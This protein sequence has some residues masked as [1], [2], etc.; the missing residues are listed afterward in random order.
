[1]ENV[2]KR[3]DNKL[4]YTERMA[5]KLIRRPSYRDVIIFNEDLSL[6][7]MAFNKVVLNKPVFV[8]QCVLDNSKYVMYDLLYNKLRPWYDCH[9]DGKVELCGG[10]TDS[11]FLKLNDLD[12][13]Q[14]V[15]P[16]M[17]ERQIFGHI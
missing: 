12:V 5:N 14:F 10:D 1:M 9:N 17:I 2:R 4:C 7:R 15:I 8:G 13:P 16:D 6:F 3:N 11:F